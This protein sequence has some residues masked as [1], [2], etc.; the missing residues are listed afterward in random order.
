MNLANRIA[1]LEELTKI[2]QMKP[3]T[4]VAPPTNEPWHIFGHE[5]G[6]QEEAKDYLH[7]LGF[8]I[9]QLIFDDI[10]LVGD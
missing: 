8:K 10:P 4:I 2:Y 7:V 6:N 1:R 3:I 5:F 9:N